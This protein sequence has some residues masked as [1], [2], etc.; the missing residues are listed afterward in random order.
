MPFLKQ[1]D[2]KLRQDG[3]KVGFVPHCVNSP[4]GNFSVAAKVRSEGPHRGMTE[5]S[6]M[7]A[8]GRSYRARFS[9]CAKTFQ[10]PGGKMGS[11]L[12]FRTCAYNGRLRLPKVAVLVHSVDMTTTSWAIERLLM[13]RRT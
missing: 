7:S 12:S 2:F 4:I 5:G 1:E 11:E 10:A 13:G 3:S 8:M 6:S 9:A